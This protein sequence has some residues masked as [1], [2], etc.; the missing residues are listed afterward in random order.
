MNSM[1]EK[2]KNKANFVCIYISEAHATDEWFLYS[3]ACVKQPKTLEE[4][5]NVASNY[6]TKF[7]ISFPVVVDSITN[8]ADK[9]YAAWPERLF[10]IQSKRI[11]FKGKKGPEG[12]HPEEV[13]A[14]LEAYYSSFK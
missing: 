9:G 1:F 3:E 5:I 8:E 4:R 11:V 10:V 6:M 7:Q 14:W 2:Y 13:E 12:Y